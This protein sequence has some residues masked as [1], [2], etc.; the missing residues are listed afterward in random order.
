MDIKVVLER[1]V[2]Q[3]V[4]SIGIGHTHTLIEGIKKKEA[5]VIIGEHK[6]AQTLKIAVNKKL[7]VLTLQ[8]IDNGAMAGFKLPLVFD[9]HA[10]VQ[11]AGHAIN[12]INVLESQVNQLKRENSNYA[13]NI[14]RAKAIL[15]EGPTPRIEGGH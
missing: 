12:R 1:I 6:D 10:I 3:Y 7:K 11:L 14:A 15:S 9:N 4:S 2:F 8:Q 5:L 13:E